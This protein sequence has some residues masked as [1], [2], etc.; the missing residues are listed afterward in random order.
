[1]L[2]DAL[3]DGDFLISCLGDQ[4]VV[5]LQVRY[6]GRIVLPHFQLLVVLQGCILDRML[7]LNLV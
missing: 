4:E 1:M 3:F 5:P 6:L 2:L 7:V